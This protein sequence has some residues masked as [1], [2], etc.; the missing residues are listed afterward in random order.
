MA[1]E[2]MLNGATERPGSVPKGKV[3]HKSKR[4][5]HRVASH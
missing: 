1:T 4:S 5:L 2:R 3:A